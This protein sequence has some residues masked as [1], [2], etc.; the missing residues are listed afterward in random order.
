MKKDSRLVGRESFFRGKIMEYALW[1][2]MTIRL[3]VELL[4]DHSPSVGCAVLSAVAGEGSS[5]F[6]PL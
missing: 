4:S 2:C 5:V 1:I 6:S 3:I